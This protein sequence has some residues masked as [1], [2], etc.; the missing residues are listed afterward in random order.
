MRVKSIR[1]FSVL[2]ILFCAFF[3]L[4]SFVPNFVSSSNIVSQLSVNSSEKSLVKEGEEVGTLNSL[5]LALE[6]TS[7]Y[8]L[9]SKYSLYS[10]SGFTGESENLPI[11]VGNQL[12]TDLCWAF[13]TN[14]ALE[15]TIY[16]LGLAS[17]SDMLNF[18]EIDMA[19]YVYILSRGRTSIGSG[20][21]ELAYEYLSSETGPVIQDEK[22][23]SLRW[24]SN[25]LLTASYT[26]LLNTYS[27]T[28]SGYSVMEAVF[29]PS[30]EA[31]LY[32][33]SALGES[34][35][36]TES[37]ILDLRN[38]IKNHIK[39]YGAVTT[40][41][42]YDK[43]YLANSYV[44]SY[45]GNSQINHM[46]TLVGWDDNFVNGNKTGAYI[47]QNSYG[48]SFGRNG[49]FYIMYDDVNVENDVVGFT[50]IGELVDEKTIYNSTEMSDKK[51]Q[52]VTLSGFNSYS[53]S[54]VTA[55]ETQ[56]IYTSNIFKANGE[57]EVIT[58]L[59]I[60]T[61]STVSRN[62]S[63]NLYDNN[64]TNYFRVYL[65][66]LSSSDV[67]EYDSA[68]KNN[69]DKKI[70]VENKYAIGEDKYLFSSTQTGYYTIEIDSDLPLQSDYFAIIVE[71][72]PG[73]SV[74][75][76]NNNE[77]STV[78]IPSYFS[79]YP[80][81]SWE[82]YTSNNLEC[83]LPMIVESVNSGTI[84]FEVSSV[85]EEY[86]GEVIKPKVEVKNLENYTIHYSLNG[87]DY[88]S[89]DDYNIKNV[90]RG[91]LGEIMS[92]TV[93]I[94]ISSN[95]YKTVETEAS[96]TITPRTLN[97]IPNS[98]LAKSYGD[99]EK[100]LTY[101]LS[102]LVKGESP[103]TLGRL[104]R[105]LG[106]DVGSYEITLGNL[107]L[108]SS[109]TFDIENYDV[110]FETGVPFTIAPREL[111]V[112]VTSNSKVYGELD[113]EFEFNIV[114]TLP[115]ETPH[116]EAS[117][118]R[119][120]G[121]NVGSYSFSF[122][123]DPQIYDNGKFKASNYIVT[124]NNN[125]KFE[126]T[127]RSLYILPDN[128][129]T[130]VYGE[131]D[132]DLTFSYSNT[133]DGQ[134]PLFSG[135]L[136][137]EGGNSVGDHLIT[138]GSLS[139]ENNGLFIASNYVL[140]IEEE[141]YF[142]ISNG[143]ITDAHVD[144]VSVTY[145]GEEHGIEVN[146]GDGIN[147]SYRLKGT[148]DYSAAELLF[149]DAGTYEIEVLFAKENYYD[150]TLSAVLTISRKDLTVLPLENQSKIYGDADNILF[151]YSGEVYGEVPGFAGALN[152]EAGQSVGVY[153]INAGTLTLSNTETFNK[154]NYNLIFSN[155]TNTCYEITKR[156]IVITPNYTTKTYG[157]LDPDI[158]FNYSN[159]YYNDQFSFSGSLVRESGQN[160][161]SY[162]ILVG[163]LS[164]GRSLQTN[165]NL[166]FSSTPIYFEILPASIT[167]SID[168]KEA[169]YGEV[170][171][172]Y[173]YTITGNYVGGDNLNLVFSCL[174]SNNEE[175]NSSSL[176]NENGYDILATYDNDNYIATIV[177]G[178]YYIK[179]KTYNV[180][181]I[182]FNGAVSSLEN[183]E[184]FSCVTSL[185]EGLNTSILGY[186]FLGW[187][188][189]GTDELVDISSYA[190]EKDTTF[191]AK[192][193]PI[194]YNLSFV[195]N[196]GSF[197]SDIPPLTYTIESDFSLP[198][199]SRLGYNFVG[200]YLSQD[201]SGEQVSNLKGMTGD[202]TLY[203]KFDI[204]V[205][206]VIPPAQNDVYEVLGSSNIE[207][208]KD[209]EFTVVLEDKYNKSY[210]NLNAYA[211]YSETNER[212]KLDR[213][214]KS[215]RALSSNTLGVNFVVKEVR[216]EFSIELENITLNVY[217]IN[218]VI[219]NQIVK[220][221][222]VTHGGSLN[223]EEYPSIPTKEHYDDTLPR[224]SVE[225]GIESVEEDLN[226]N[227]IYT[228]N[229]YNVTF[230]LNGNSYD[231][232]V[233]Y[234]EDVSTSVLYDNY[235]LGLFEYF[236]FDR[237]LSGIDTDTIINVSV[238]SNIYIL[239]I[240]LGVVSAIIIALI[241]L[242][243]IK[244]KKRNK[245]DWWVFGK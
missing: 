159:L 209:Y 116:I 242:T 90:L 34:S 93:Y 57:N 83:V 14:T 72:L 212:V 61:V 94:R 18:S 208:G 128:G 195:L 24:D 186:D 15:S 109:S 133:L 134:T 184:H 99:D 118:T 203:A 40:S 101:T 75:Y 44:Y 65:L 241:I 9:E 199:P 187:K 26:E 55:S 73:G 122:A 89:E 97:I 56:S 144:N 39:T 12:S 151:S 198:T 232:L 19:Y 38:M 161:G 88:F 221:I 102:G 46:V 28:H 106:E 233:V 177:S 33:S 220:S 157:T 202:K 80:N 171:H 36:E 224:W 49:Y 197:G 237:S 135:K 164:L 71:T 78:S 20:G 86:S 181:F 238:A 27:P 45:S 194:S 108:L 207:F 63:S 30:R 52:F 42:Y 148:L 117:L 107:E 25:S 43:A 201:F 67:I 98:G 59:K 216:G 160:V 179:Y 206:D 168:D 172:N 76:I 219:D 95:L 234:G 22:E 120:P 137:W 69:F 156:D 66:N 85:T 58:R 112:E 91:D 41:I 4:F 141:V 70:P 170:D 173:T 223:V 217:D 175:I 48:S 215:T 226:I 176:R 7:S 192:F 180:S 127:P 244:R 162:Q 105:A 35:E 21:F 51:D 84:D 129:Q 60:P 131:S 169:F 163:S 243:I 236:T 225:N 142:N 245:F 136:S 166:V 213:V 1:K 222:D 155:P 183:V 138:L 125:I 50:R 228:P 214:D 79:R 126:I 10:F 13:S 104:S 77:N 2:F 119:T 153:V 193:S 123:L 3:A 185:P 87:E 182:G 47:A 200:F 64:K 196:G 68:L 210:D 132:P 227:A 152:R 53:T 5:S 124:L 189:Y 146:A 82:R 205:F 114:N 149:K 110:E 8:N 32:N 174:D 121:E 165:Y 158:S 100:I 37:K 62:S 239:Y 204:I 145:D 147:V 211:L 31:I 92:Y 96:V 115:N 218:F 167:I 74:L 130:K 17:Q 188:V 154:N 229:V 235:K 139:I 178:K 29:F 190:I 23:S 81:S 113:P 143:E 230:V 111:V 240:V 231:A 150:L 16:K 140:E 6:D 191:V 11:N 103:K 54:Y